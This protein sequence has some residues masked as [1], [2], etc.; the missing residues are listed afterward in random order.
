MVHRTT[1]SVPSPTFSKP[2]G[3]HT[4]TDSG[5]SQGWVVGVVDAGPGICGIGEVGST[6]GLGRGYP[7]CSQVGITGF[8]EDPRWVGYPAKATEIYKN[9]PRG[10]NIAM[11][12]Q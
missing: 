1:E 7:T 10:R 4:S 8:W 11:M 5:R 6:V 12:T 2:R 3:I 9:E